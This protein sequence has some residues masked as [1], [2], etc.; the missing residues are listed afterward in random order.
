MTTTEER[1]WANALATKYGI[2]RPL[3]DEPVLP[4]G[5]A[6]SLALGE[7]HVP[8]TGTRSPATS[9]TASR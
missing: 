7:C 1:V 2:A 5:L 9:T 4:L 6:A 8:T 3:A